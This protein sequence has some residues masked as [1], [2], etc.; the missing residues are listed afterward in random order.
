MI[1]YRATYQALPAQRGKLR[2][3]TFAARDATAAEKIAEDWQIYDRLLTV[4]PLRALQ[5]RLELE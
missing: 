4:R 2:G 1:L 3:M 5:Q